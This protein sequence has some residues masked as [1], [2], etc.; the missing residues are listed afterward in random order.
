MNILEVNHPRKPYKR[1]VAVDD[2]SFS[3]RDGSCFGLL[4]P[5]GAGKATTLEVIEHIQPASG[6]IV[7]YKGKSRTGSS[8]EEI[9][10]QFQHTSLLN[11]LSVKETLLCYRNLYKKPIDLAPISSQRNNQLSGCQCQRLMLALFFPL[12]HLLKA[13]RKIMNE[14]AD[15]ADI[16]LEY[17]LFCVSSIFSLCL[18]AYLFS[19]NE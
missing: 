18:A 6:D 14:G 16:Q 19:W 5:N 1:K 7:S 9:G 17:A 13:A 12:T 2:V 10:I 15:L 3:V 8:R 11:Y 4:G